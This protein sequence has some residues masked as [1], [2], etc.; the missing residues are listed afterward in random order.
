MS[1]RE[2]T[3]LPLQSALL[4]VESLEQAFIVKIAQRK[5][6]FPIENIAVAARVVEAPT[7]LSVVED[8][9]DSIDLYDIFTGS[10]LQ[11]RLVT[12]YFGD[13]LKAN[14]LFDRWIRALH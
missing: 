5:N 6:E 3:F 4:F 7:S 12:L 9:D 13:S 14:G 8:L 10:C 2:M 1:T 11:T